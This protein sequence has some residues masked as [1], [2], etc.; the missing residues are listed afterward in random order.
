MVKS[1]IAR[2]MGTPYLLDPIDEGAGG[3]GKPEGGTP[4]ADDNGA[5]NLG[6]DGKPVVKQESKTPVE[7]PRIKGMLADLQKERTA[8]QK[9]EKEA[10]EHRVS[11]DA[12]RKRVQALAGLTPKTA[13]EA[14]EELVKARLLKLFPQLNGNN[15]DVE[16][17]KA[18]IAEL[19]KGTSTQWETHGKKMLGRVAAGVEKALGSG[20]LSE[21]QTNRIQ[22]AYVR[23]AES[24]PEFLARHEAGDETLIAEFVEGWLEDFVKPA[25][26]KALAADVGRRQR[27]PNGN[28]RSAVGAGEKKI[29]VKDD[30]AVEDLLVKGFR[31]RGGQFG[32]R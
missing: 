13:E 11:L 16:D 2:L 21:R 20:K 30:K 5:T 31:D 26:R 24:N 19:R 15:K 23:E 17:L 9:Y 6:A 8:R 1:F 29:D 3:G 22:V 4:G 27:V 18:E 12:E 10:N 32:H 14:D 7:D 25:E 28:G